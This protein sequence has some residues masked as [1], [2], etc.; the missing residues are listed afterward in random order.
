[1]PTDPIRAQDDGR[2]SVL[3]LQ[4]EY[5]RLSIDRAMDA[6]PPTIHGSYQTSKT[7]CST[8][9]INLLSLTAYCFPSLITLQ[10]IELFGDGALMAFTVGRVQIL[11]GGIYAVMAGISL[12]MG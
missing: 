3:L 11:G 10:A 4:R 9:T 8:N 6:C 7:F 5:P 12:H 2:L 1:M